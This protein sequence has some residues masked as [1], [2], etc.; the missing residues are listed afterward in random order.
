MQTLQ[1]VLE[2][3]LA[4]SGAWL[5]IMLVYQ[6]FLTVF[7]FRRETKDYQDHDPQSRFLILVPSRSEGRGSAYTVLHL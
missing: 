7:G 1:T 2:A 4:L 6:L 5:M 3:I